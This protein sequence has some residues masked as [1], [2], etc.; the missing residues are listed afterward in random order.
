MKTK[1]LSIV[2]FCFV[3][4][5]AA[6]Q[7]ADE[8]VNKALAARGGADK[9]KAVQAERITGSVS[10]AP[11][12]EGTFVVELKR[13][14]KM[15]TEIS[16]GGQKIIRVYDGK[17]A[18]WMLNLF[19]ENK[20]VQAMSAEDLKN[21]SDETD[22]DGPLVDY[23]AKGNKIELVGKEELD[24]K[25]VYRVKLT[26]QNGDVR[27]YLFDASSFLTLKWEGIRRAENK[28][29]PWES[30]FSDFREVRGLLY[31]FKIEQGS[32]GTNMK[33]T[34]VA[35]KIEIDPQ[36]DESRFAKPQSPM[37]PANPPATPSLAP[38]SAS[39]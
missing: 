10:F 6:A 20:D 34:L 11:G 9:I 28:E 27:F 35:E 24:A 29:I 33:Q 3:P 23:K 37:P 31:P 16:V 21:I 25:P 4:V 7:T 17:S 15:H 30:N 14:H 26:Y 8:I 22:F 5:T 38:P 39:L 32:P 2:L 36:I 1:F 12:V 18:G 19:A 13:P